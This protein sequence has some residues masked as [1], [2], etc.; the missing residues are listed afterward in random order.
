MAISRGDEATGSKSVERA[1]PSRSL[2]GTVRH[3]RA[4]AG[5]R[6]T[7]QPRM[8]SARLVS[9]AG[10]RIA[11]QPHLPLLGMVVTEPAGKYAR[12][13]LERRFLLGRLP[14]GI[15]RDDGWI[16]TDRY[17]TR[18]RLR[19]RRMEPLGGGDTVFKLGQKEAPHPPDFS[20]AVLTNIYLSP[21]EYA[22]LVHLPAHEL[23]KRRYPFHWGDHLYVVD[24]FEG[25]LTGLVLAEIG[26][27]T[28]EEMEAYSQLPDFAL[29]DVSRDVRFTGGALAFTSPEEA[30]QL[31][32]EFRER[33]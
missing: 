27:S 10:A 5:G 2:A 32:L 19:L 4:S 9:T 15:S 16:I 12:I 29:R 28:I 25:N 13:E 14:E 6:S 7:E 26:F 3:V 11:P 23:R 8:R 20:R 33:I 22:A 24:A 1:T 31:V 18:T 17:L 21:Q 30:A